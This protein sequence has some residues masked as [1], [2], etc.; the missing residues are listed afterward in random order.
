[1]ASEII[2]LRGLFRGSYHWGDFSERLSTIFPEYSVSCID[3]PG[4]G[5]LSLEASPNTIS[6]M[7]ESVRNQRKGQGKVSILAVSMGGM[8]GLK[9]AELYPDEVESVIC[10]NTTAKGFSP[11][12]ERLLPL[13]YLRIVRAIFSS[14]LNRE[15]AIY[16]MVANQPLNL[17]VVNEWANKSEKYPMSVTNFWRQLRAAVGFVV[18]RP[19]CELHFV[20]SLNDGLVNFKANKAIANA[21]GAPVIVNE[22]DGHDI[23]LDNPE[24]LLRVVRSI[25]PR[26]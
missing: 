9:W 23:A 10:V 20:A 15:I 22:I 7:V 12:Y 5:Y 1:M 21:W 18:S 13:N 14:S 24:W 17:K 25:Y 2:L 26:Y 19:Q 16:Q 3:I 11:F 8:V 4:N 6:A